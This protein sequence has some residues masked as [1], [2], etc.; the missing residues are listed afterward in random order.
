MLNKCIVSG[1]EDLKMLIQEQALTIRVKQTAADQ[2]KNGIAF[3]SLLVGVPGYPGVHALSI[4]F[5][6]Q[7]V[8]RKNRLLHNNLPDR[9]RT[10]TESRVGVTNGEPRAAASYAGSRQALGPARVAHEKRYSGSGRHAGLS[11]G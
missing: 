8:K 4:A 5:V 6:L 2:N 7:L 9:I 3:S 1:F 11:L 10:C